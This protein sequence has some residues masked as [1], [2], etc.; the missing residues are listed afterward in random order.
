MNLFSG[1]KR[2]K[3]SEKPHRSHADLIYLCL[4]P[5]Y[6]ETQCLCVFLIEFM[7]VRVQ[8]ELIVDILQCNTI[9]KVLAVRTSPICLSHISPDR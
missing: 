4:S 9:Q 3:A 1:D 8:N 5:E 6:D 2:E 7:S